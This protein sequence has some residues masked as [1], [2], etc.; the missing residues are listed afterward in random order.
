LPVSL[1]GLDLSFLKDPANRLPPAPR[2]QRINHRAKR[3]DK[4]ASPYYFADAKPYVNVA[5]KENLVISSRSQQREFEKRTGYVQ[6]GNDIPIGS[7]AAENNAKKARWDEL[8]KGHT[9]S[10]EWVD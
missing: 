5:T 2:K 7:I 6:V 10:P 3:S 8:S 9:T 1:A 4:V